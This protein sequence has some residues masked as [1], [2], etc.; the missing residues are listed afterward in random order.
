MKH[1]HLY[2]PVGHSP[3]SAP[4]NSCFV[5]AYAHACRSTPRSLLSAP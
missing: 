4:L 3:D 5:K 1:V 2:P